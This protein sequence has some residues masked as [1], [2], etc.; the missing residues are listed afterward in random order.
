MPN[1]HCSSTIGSSIE[2]FNLK[3]YLSRFDRLFKK[4]YGHSITITL[5]KRLLRGKVTDKI[6][7]NQTRDFRVWVIVFF[8]Q[9]W[10]M[11][12]P[13]FRIRSRKLE[14][15][16]GNF[17]FQSLK[18]WPRDV[19]KNLIKLAVNEIKTEVIYSKLAFLNSS[20][21]RKSRSIFNN[22]KIKIMQLMHLKTFEL[23]RSSS[24]RH[25]A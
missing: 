23:I 2:T 6:W 18:E 24:F 12:T 15:W 21:P 25:N 1:G 8:T 7:W 22:L 10:W 4:L 11:T 3:G 16:K 9:N 5:A 20:A 13:L 14:S 19:P 17:G